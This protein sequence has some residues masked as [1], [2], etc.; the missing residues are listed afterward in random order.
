MGVDACSSDRKRPA[1]VG[2]AATIAAVL[3]ISSWSLS[4]AALGEAAP[5]LTGY[6]V[7]SQSLSSPAWSF[8]ESPDGATLTADW[9]GG[10]FHETL[11][12]HFDGMAKGV[13]HGYSGAYKIF[14]A[15]KEFPGTMLVIPESPGHI[16]ITLKG[17]NGSESKYVFVRLVGPIESNAPIERVAAPGSAV[18]AYQVRFVSNLNLGDSF[19]NVTNK[20]VEG[21]AAIEPEAA[22][23]AQGV[24]ALGPSATSDRHKQVILGSARFKAPAHHTVKLSLKLNTQARKLV[25]TKGSLRT[26]LQIRLNA[27]SGLPRV[28]KV[29]TLTFLKAVAH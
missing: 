13:A 7:N 8:N 4:S 1:R 12:G 9:R 18:D 16:T 21:E 2:R 3:A 5:S 29:A 22:A 17:V 27:S 14:E 6:W 23:H 15:G 20:G 19:V 11:V 24:R 25:L 28:T 10:A 26:R